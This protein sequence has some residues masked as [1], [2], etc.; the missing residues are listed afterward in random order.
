MI[1]LKQTA[2]QRFVNQYKGSWSG[3]HGLIQCIATAVRA[4]HYNEID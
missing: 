1:Y 3:I 2:I 4:I